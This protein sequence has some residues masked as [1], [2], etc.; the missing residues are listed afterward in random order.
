[1]NDLLE[2]E[3]LDHMS[4]VVRGRSG[5]RPVRCSSRRAGTS[6]SR[7]RSQRA[8]EVDR[9]DIEQADKLL[10]AERLALQ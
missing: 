2:K 4:A 10:L 7:D 9:D 5:D 1:M 8:V 3:L 6:D